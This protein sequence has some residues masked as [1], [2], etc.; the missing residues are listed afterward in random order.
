MYRLI[1]AGVE[2]MLCTAL[3]IMKRNGQAA[4]PLQIGP[5]TSRFVEEDEDSQEEWRKN[6]GARR[7]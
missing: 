6:L 1:N 7:N 5:G 3:K 4:A 2:T